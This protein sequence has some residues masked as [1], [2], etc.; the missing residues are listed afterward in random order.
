ME[1]AAVSIKVLDEL[2]PKLINRI[3]DEFSHGMLGGFKGCI[4]PD[5]DS[6]FCFGSG[7]DNWRGIVC[8]DRVCRGL[9]GDGK[10][11]TPSGGVQHCRFDDA[12]KVVCS[13]LIKR[14]LKKEGVEDFP[15]RG[16][17]IVGWLTNNGLE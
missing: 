3:P 13:R 4:I 8:N 9:S 12:D 6:M 1:A 5:K 2:L 7:A 14:N 15:E 11:C 10:V 16:E 17:A